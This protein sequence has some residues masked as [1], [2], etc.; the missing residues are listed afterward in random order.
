MGIG[1]VFHK[2]RW[3]TPKIHGYV[4]LEDMPV[5]REAPIDGRDPHV[6]LGLL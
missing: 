5:I 2:G 6:I 4:Q 1:D 3:L